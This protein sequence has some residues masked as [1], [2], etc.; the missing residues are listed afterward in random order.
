MKA[1]I[2]IGGMGTRLRP[3]TCTTPKPL[4]P[5]VN[6]PFLEYQ[7]QLLKKHGIKEVVLCVAY[8]SHEFENYFGNGRK[9][10]IKIEY[11]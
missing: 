11:V 8:M 1:L 7:F 2:L 3:L 4:L 6:R 9:W 10:G 5:I